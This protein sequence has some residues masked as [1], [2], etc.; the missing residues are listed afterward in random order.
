MKGIGVTPDPPLPTVARRNLLTQTGGGPQGPAWLQEAIKPGSLLVPAEGGRGLRR[1]G[2]RAAEALPRI[3]GPQEHAQE[4]VGGAAPPRMSRVA[5]WTTGI[6]QSRVG[7]GRKVLEGAG[8][9]WKLPPDRYRVRDEERGGARDGDSWVAG[10]GSGG[11][12]KGLLPDAGPG[13][14]CVRRGDQ[15]AYRRQALHSR[16]EQRE[17]GAEEKFKEIF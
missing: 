17:P 3:L 6:G 14:R 15:G 4:A 1:P 16:T 9:L 11:N 5:A 2:A 12:G 8:G 13:P 10:R 7:A